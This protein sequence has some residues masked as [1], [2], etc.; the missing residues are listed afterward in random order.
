MAPRRGKTTEAAAGSPTEGQTVTEAIA[1]I[2]DQHAEP[3]TNGHVA[4]PS[5]RP[6][7]H[8][9]AVKKMPGKLGIKA[10]DLVVELVDFG[11]SGGVGIRVITPE[12]R[13]L[14][15][16]EKDIIRE[17]VK[18]EEGKPSGFSWQGKDRLWHKPIKRQGEALD[19]VPRARAV[20]I[21]LDAEGR[22][23]ALADA[24]SQHIDPQGFAARIEQ[25]RAEAADRDRIPD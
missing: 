1:A 2:P 21:R 9:Q 16:A 10:G 25:Q 6:R 5:S 18:G 24:L 22:V 23:N 3:P 15:D 11:N 12:G 8:A 4:N 17:N 13:Q 19:D 14:T 7:S 20:A